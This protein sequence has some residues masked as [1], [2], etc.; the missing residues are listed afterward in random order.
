MSGSPTRLL[1]I[2]PQ[3]VPRR[4]IVLSAA[5]LGLARVDEAATLSAAERLLPGCRYDTVVLALD[6]GPVPAVQRLLAAC[7]P[8][9][10][11]GIV[12]PGQAEVARA[13]QAD[14]LHKLLDRPA[15]VKDLLAWMRVQAAAPA[16]A[17][18]QPP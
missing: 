18:M 12:A 1:V 2:E 13:L 16:A 14:G 17:G 4:T 6:V 9:R 11:I 8:A 15:R 10:V 7:A 3:F 5:R